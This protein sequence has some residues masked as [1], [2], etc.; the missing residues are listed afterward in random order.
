MSVLFFFAG[1]F[2]PSSLKKDGINT[3]IRKKLKRLGLPL[4]IVVPIFSPTYS[5]IYHYTHNGYLNKL[6]FKTYWWNYMKG[7]LEFYTG[8]I[9]P[10]DYF[11]HSHLWFI[12][13]LLFFFIAYALSAYLLRWQEKTRKPTSSITKL[14]K[15]PLILFFLV[16]VLSSLSSLLANTFFSEPFDMAPWVVVAN[17]L[18]FQPIHVISYMLYFSLG[19]YGYHKKWITVVKIGGHPLMWSCITILL[20]IL[21]FTVVN[22]VLK[23][24]SPSFALIYLFVRSLLCVSFLVTFVKLAS[25][26]WNCSSNFDKRLTANSYTIYLIHFLIIILLQ[27][28]LTGWLDGPVLM[29]F[30]IATS[31]SILISYLISQYII[32]PYP[33][34]STIGAYIVFAFFLFSIQSSGS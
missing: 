18:H 33:R 24:P 11:H 12:S 23:H 16:A 17:I 32:R 28:L 1:Y 31:G 10:I 27:L 29:K 14:G 9:C 8:T 30:G 20:S 5:Y 15:P 21:L 2:A 6:S 19:V 4:L 3:F 34:L 22:W 13:L 26:Y 25:R 7:G